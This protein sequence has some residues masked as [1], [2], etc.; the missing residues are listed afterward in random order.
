MKDRT[1]RLMQ[2]TIRKAHHEVSRVKE[3]NNPRNR[4]LI[5]LGEQ[6][7]ELQNTQLKR[8]HLLCKQR[9]CAK[10]AAPTN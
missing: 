6:K 9:I 5:K 3:N 2:K 8:K 1:I 4:L 7:K 10:E